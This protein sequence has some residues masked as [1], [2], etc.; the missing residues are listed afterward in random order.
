M[1]VDGGIRTGIDV[2]K[3]LSRGN[4]DIFFL[5]FMLHVLSIYAI[6]SHNSH[7]HLFFPSYFTFR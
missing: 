6:V 7:I 1:F 5:Y 4:W 2:F 3:A